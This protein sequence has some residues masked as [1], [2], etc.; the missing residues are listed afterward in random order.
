MENDDINVLISNNIF[1]CRVAAL[2]EK[3][4]KILFQ[5]RKNDLV[6]ALPGGKIRVLEKLDDGIRREIFE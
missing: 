3:N 1:T 5:K 6:W 4:G 2:I